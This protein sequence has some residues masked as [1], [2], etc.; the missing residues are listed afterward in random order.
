MGRRS[1]KVERRDT[2]SWDGF[3]GSEQRSAHLV[4]GQVYVDVLPQLV[5]GE[6]VVDKILELLLESG[7]EVGACREEHLKK[8]IMDR[9]EHMKL[10]KV[11]QCCN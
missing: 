11:P 5:S 4:T 3:K 8:N 7:H 1:G 6:F 2:R 9:V 10:A